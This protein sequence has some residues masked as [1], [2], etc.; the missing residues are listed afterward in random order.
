MAIL[1]GCYLLCSFTVL[2]PTHSIRPGYASADHVL[3]A[4][5]EKLVSRNTLQHTYQLELNYA[6][7]DYHRTLA[8]T[9]FLDFTTADSI[10]GFRYLLEGKGMKLVYN[11]TESFV[12]DKG[13]KTMQLTIHPKVSHFTGITAFH[14]SLV[15]LRKTLPGIIADRSIEK[16]LADTTMDNREY[17]LIRLK[18]NKRV[19]ERLGGFSELSTDRKNIYELIVDKSSYLPVQFIQRNSVNSDYML[20]VIDNIVMDAV[21]PSELSWY[22]SSYT[23]QYKLTRKK[24]LQPLKEQ[25][26]APDWELPLPG[27]QEVVQLRQLKGKVVLL[28]FWTKNCGYCISVVPKLNSLM[29]KFQ[30]EDVVVLGVMRMI[31][32]RKLVTSIKRTDRTLKQC[33]RE[34]VFPKYMA[35]GISQPL[36]YWTKKEWCFTRGNTTRRLLRA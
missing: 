33:I 12:L 10:I 20:T 8:G 27:G 21:A 19:I 15:T 11:G 23:D 6:S 30:H 32:R 18:L 26:T 1:S 28:E 36:C 34:K 9:T 31:R 22:Y 3:S 29:K 17:Y 25:A 2:N 16:S 24:V 7:E 5:Y 14:N 4:V 35:S 13:Q